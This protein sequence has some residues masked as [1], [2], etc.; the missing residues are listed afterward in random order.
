ML[1][2]EHMHQKNLQSVGAAISSHAGSTGGFHAAEAGCKHYEK[3]FT[4]LIIQPSNM[5]CI[6]QHKKDLQ[7]AKL[8]QED[9]EVYKEKMELAIAEYRLLK[10]DPASK[11]TI[12]S[13]AKDWNLPNPHWAIT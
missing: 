1:L 10:E 6:S 7:A 9:W 5:V 4:L 8:K 2:C 3:H 11:V 12:Q 13:V